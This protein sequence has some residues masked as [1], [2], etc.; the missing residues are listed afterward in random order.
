MTPAQFPS[1]QFS[2]G[3]EFFNPQTFLPTPQ[4]PQLVDTI[5]IVVII[6]SARSTLRQIPYTTLTTQMRPWAN[7]Q[8]YPRFWSKV[9]PTQYVI[10]PVP[11]MTY[12]CEFDVAVGPSV[13]LGNPADDDPDIP[14]PYQD[15]VQYFAAYK[16]KINQQ[17][18]QEATAFL[19]LYRS[20]LVRV[21]AAYWGRINPNPA[22]DR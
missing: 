16:A 20:E 17:Q 10:A 3:F 9:S 13:A 2:A 15:I 11:S 19:G 6:N 21:T 22:G 12:Q 1:L 7:Y 4:G 14:V 8:S 18:L 5:N